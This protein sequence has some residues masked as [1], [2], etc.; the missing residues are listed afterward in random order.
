MQ[1]V[2]LSGRTFAVDDDKP[3]FWERAANGQWE[4]ELLADLAAALGP[5]DL[6]LDIGGW[7][8]PISLLAASCGAHV[9]ALEP[10]P[11]AARQFRANVAANP[12]LASR[13]TL[14]EA[15]LTPDGGPVTLGSPRKPGDSMSS[16]LLAGK[17]VA[18]WEAESLSPAALVARLPA[19]QRLFIKI[20][21]EGGEYQLGRA[22]APL[23]KLQ[24]EAVWLG[25]HPAILSASA[26][27]DEAALKS[28]TQALFAVWEGLMPQILGSDAV[29]VLGEAL[30]APITV[31]FSHP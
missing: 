14:I 13:I 21:I 15:A 2:T 10:D 29:D 19:F 4:P 27:K 17:G 23:A 12:D 28:D 20:D 1:R 26:Q 8:G 18:N 6:L 3:S 7:V 11:A 16:L 30:R 31:K 24:P 9:V 25:F 22:F 5:G